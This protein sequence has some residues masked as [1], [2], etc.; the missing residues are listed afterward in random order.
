MTDCLKTYVVKNSDEPLL[1]MLK[2][3]DLD[4]EQCRIACR[5]DGRNYFYLP[6]Q[7]R[8]S[9]QLKEIAYEFGAADYA[10]ADR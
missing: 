1:K 2:G 10:E 9:E 4:F 3:I 8:G 6:E 7:F 5:R